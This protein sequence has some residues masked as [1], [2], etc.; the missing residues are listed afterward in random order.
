[1][2]FKFG[3]HNNLPNDHI[4]TT[5]PLETFILFS[6]YVQYFQCNENKKFNEFYL[7]IFYKTKI[8]TI[9]SI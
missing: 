8:K 9:E 1:M 2:V 4:A 5:I 3:G 7:T 6:N